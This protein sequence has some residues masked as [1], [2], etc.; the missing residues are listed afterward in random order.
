[1]KDTSVFER[2]YWPVQ[3]GGNGNTRPAKLLRSLADHLEV[4][5]ARRFIYHG[6]SE[7]QPGHVRANRLRPGQG[8]QTNDHKYAVLSPAFVSLLASASWTDFYDD[9]SKAPDINP[10]YRAYAMA[11][12]RRVAAG[13]TSGL[14]TC[15]SPYMA[16]KLRLGQEAIVPNGFD[17]KLS[18][19]EL[20]GDNRRRLIV[21][22]HFFRGRTDYELLERF[23]TS[24]GFDEIVIG[25]PGR[26]RE[27]GRALSALADH[28]G[29]ALEVRK[30][31][32][33][34]EL[35]RMVGSRTVALVPHIVS[36]YTLSQDLM[37]VY[38]YLALGAKVACPRLLWPAALPI[39]HAYLIDFGNS[40]DSIREWVD[41]P[42]P[43]ASERSD[44]AD[45]HSWEARG[46]AL[47]RLLEKS[48]EA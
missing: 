22:G 36:D 47:A 4:E 32:A 21:Q 15:N 42:R 27:M 41:H 40:A 43:T 26:S 17:G 14:V 37:K 46:A 16:A 10:V 8:E 19:V 30:W 35:A 18:D 39:T 28:S 6:A 34:E 5:P 1:M 29:A 2:V 20:S 25:A 48:Y 31:I 11:G 13:K 9:W 3:P 7:E 23:A 38:K 24:G 44:L 45:S 33:D 12:Y